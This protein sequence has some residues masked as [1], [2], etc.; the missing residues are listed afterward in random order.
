MTKIDGEGGAGEM[1]P[2]PPHPPPNNPTNFKDALG[3]GVI[4]GF[5]HPFNSRHML[6]ENQIPIANTHLIME[7]KIMMVMNTPGFISFVNGNHVARSREWDVRV[8]KLT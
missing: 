4:L 2:P 3:R 7:I 8:Y 5:I 6:L 1:S